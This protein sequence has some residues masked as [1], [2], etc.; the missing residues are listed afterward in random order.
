M[1]SAISS[2][3]AARRVRTIEGD[4]RVP[5]LTTPSAAE[6]RACVI[7]VHQLGGVTLD[8]ELAPSPLRGGGA[9]RRPRAGSLSTP[10]DSVGQ[11][12]AVAHR[13]DQ[14]VLAVLIASRKL[15]WSETTIA[16]PSAMN[17]CIEMEKP[18]HSDGITTTSIACMYGTASSWKPANVTTVA[19]PE[20][21]GLGFEG[22]LLRPSP[23]RRN[24]NGPLCDRR[25][26]RGIDEVA[27]PL[28]LV[29]PPDGAD[30]RDAGSIPMR[31]LGRRDVVAGIEGEGVDAAVGRHDLRRRATDQLDLL[32]ASRPWSR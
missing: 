27:V 12:R 8:A 13:H 2:T 10:D 23:T 9:E 3:L 25:L 17:S 7:V 20:C 18:S 14:A 24:S 6:R 19:E 4:R 32:A 5:R 15:W 28:L 11:R 26:G 21:G 16:L 29:Q 30:D 22:L 1:A 31:R